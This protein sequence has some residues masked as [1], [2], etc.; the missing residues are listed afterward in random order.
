[1]GGRDWGGCGASA[2]RT[3]TRCYN[4]HVRPVVADVSR[5][6]SRWHGAAHE[7]ED[8]EQHKKRVGNVY[9]CVC[10]CACMRMHGVDE[11]SAGYAYGCGAGAV[12]ACAQQAYTV[13]GSAGRG[14]ERPPSRRRF[15]LSYCNTRELTEVCGSWGGWVRLQYVMN[16]QLR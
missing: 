15:P 14:V 1:M 13:E 5:W 2:V 3:G 8:V 11:K 6:H 12:C 16:T 7:T 10:D 9:V 4:A